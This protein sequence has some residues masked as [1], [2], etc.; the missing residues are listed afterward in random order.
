MATITL[1]YNARS[2]KARA[3]LDMLLCK[4]MFTKREEKRRKSGQELSI[5]VVEEARSG[6]YA[7]TAD[8]SSIYAF[9]SWAYE[10]DTLFHPVQERHQEFN[11]PSR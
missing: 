7:G 3:A 2:G 8:T 11:L 6:K 5:E 10:K 9:M 4:G 1:D